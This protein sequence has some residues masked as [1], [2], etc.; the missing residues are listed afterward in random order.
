MNGF[1]KVVVIRGVKFF[2]GNIDGKD[3]ESGKFFV[4][5]Q[6]DEVNGTAKGMYTVEY[7]APCELAKA[8]MT[9]EFPVTASCHFSMKQVNAGN[10]KAHKLTIDRFSPQKSFLDD[11]LKPKAPK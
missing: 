10:G 7:G 11:P 6:L 9:L 5:E 1:D 2:S 8:A 4:D 3:I